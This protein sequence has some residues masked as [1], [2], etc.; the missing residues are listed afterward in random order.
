MSAAPKRLAASVPR[1]AAKAGG[2]PVPLAM[3]GT[4]AAHRGVPGTHAPVPPASYVVPLAGG[5]GSV[6]GASASQA[7]VAGAPGS[8][9]RSWTLEMPAGMKLLSLNSRMHWAERGRI[10][11]DLR[12]A[13]WALAKAA[14]IPPLERARVVVEYQPP[15]VS[16]R[17]DLDNVATASGKPCID[18]AL[19]D[20]RVLADDSPEYLTEITYRLG[21]PY[22][23]GRLV[24]H[25]IEVRP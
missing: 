2:T 22:P 14:G 15:Q 25:I 19:T 1:G 20:A 3:P 24:L 18:G 23:R 21:E 9:P 17:R 5:T 16:R 10:T 13:A 6:P 8:T 7:T 4:S 11:R 12:K